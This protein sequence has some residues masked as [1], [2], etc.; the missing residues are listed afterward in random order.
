MVFRVGCCCLLAVLASLVVA[1]GASA[2]ALYG[3]YNAS[4]VNAGAV[5]SRSGGYSIRDVTA[6]IVGRVETRSGKVFLVDG[7]FLG[8]AVRKSSRLAVFV[9]GGRV[10]GRASKS[11]GHWVVKELVSGK[12][13][14]T[15]AVYGGP[16]YAAAAALRELLW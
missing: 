7:T 9:T 13:Y 15:G 6:K 2:R 10:A 16:G 1:Q 8:K 12:W 4:D 14:R 5:T 3:V 11:S